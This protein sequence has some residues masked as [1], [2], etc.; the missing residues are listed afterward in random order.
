MPQ[1]LDTVVSISLFYSYSHKDKA[2]RDKLKTHLSLM[3]RERLISEWYDQDIL[4]GQEWSDEINKHLK[5]ADI[6]LL[7]V[8]PDFIDSD[9]CYTME[10]EFAIRRYEA[11]EAWVIPI[12]LKPCEWRHSP[13]KRLQALPYRAKPVTSSYWHNQDDAFNDIAQGIRKVANNIRKSK[14]GKIATLKDE[15]TVTVPTTQS[16]PGTK[17]RSLNKLLQKKREDRSIG[18][19]LQEARELIAKCFSV[20]EIGK[21]TKGF[22]LILLFL[23]TVLDIIVLPCLVYQWTNLAL[24]AISFIIFGLLFLMGITNKNGAVAYFVAFTF[25]V[26]WLF[27]GIVRIIG[28]YH[29]LLPFYWLV[30]IVSF[31]SLLQLELFRPRNR[32]RR[33]SRIV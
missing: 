17:S 27:I 24:S 5:T 12:I 19:K 33:F 15:H 20:S 30:I 6:I 18:E 16:L 8:S 11:G 10:M 25:F 14:G 32:K 26:I 29:L 4:P 13:L 28:Y 31:L 3:R 7:L 21:R 22:Y 1:S 9:Y 23:F 2:Y